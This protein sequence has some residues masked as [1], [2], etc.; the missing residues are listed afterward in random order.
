MKPPSASITASIRIR[1]WEHAFSTSSGG[2]FVNT[3]RMAVIRLTLVLWEVML[4]MFSTYEQT[5][6]SSVF[7]SGEDGASERRVQSRSTPSETKPGSLWTSGPAPSPA[8]TP[9]V[10]HRPPDCTRVSPHSSADPGTL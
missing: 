10:C 7:R 3:L 9:S 1:N 8:A 5:K 4:V 6:K 2:S